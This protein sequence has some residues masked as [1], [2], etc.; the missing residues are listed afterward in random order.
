[1]KSGGSISSDN[2]DRDRDREMK[3]ERKTIEK[4]RRLQMKSLTLRLTSLIPASKQKQLHNQ[5][6]GLEE[7]AAYIIDLRNRVQKLKE[8]G[9][10]QTLP[11]IEVRYQ[12]PTLE[13][14]LIMTAACRKLSFHRVI[15]IIEEEGAHVVNASQSA[16]G[17]RLLYTIHSQ[18]HV[19]F[20]FLLSLIS[21]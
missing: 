10:E 6:D 7:A 1:M 12:H 17:H 5:S 4:Q 3:V 2:G 14:V 21:M 9:K 11:S 19:N 16:L 8:M 15:R 13:V 18:V 20:I